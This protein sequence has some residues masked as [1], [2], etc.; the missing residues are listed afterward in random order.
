[1]NKTA[2]V[3]VFFQHTLLLSQFDDKSTN[4]WSL[5]MEEKVRSEVPT[6]RGNGRT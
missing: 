3:H 6:G 2:A 4:R 1:M 5:L